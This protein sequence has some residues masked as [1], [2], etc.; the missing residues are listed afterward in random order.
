MISRI[1]RPSVSEGRQLHLQS[2]ISAAAER[3]ADRIHNI[4]S[5]ED[6]VLSQPVPRDLTPQ[7]QVNWLWSL[8]R[9]WAP[10]WEGRS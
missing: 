10:V 2:L 7:Q 9:Y 4:Q 3:C 6:F 8:H 5:L 1:P